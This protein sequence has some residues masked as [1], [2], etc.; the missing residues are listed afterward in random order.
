MMRCGVLILAAKPPSLALSL[1]DE[2]LGIA[3]RHAG[4]CGK[5]FGALAYEHH[6]RAVLQHRACKPDGIADVFEGRHSASAQSRTVHHDGV[7]FH[8]AVKIEVRA[9]PGIEN[10]IILEHDDR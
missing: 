3:E 1:A 10:R 9:K 7:A 4:V 2:V 8:A 6:M 5:P